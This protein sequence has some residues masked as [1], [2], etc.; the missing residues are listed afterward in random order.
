MN[1]KTIIWIGSGLVVA[2]LGYLAYNY[3]KT[4]KDAKDAE[5]EAEKAITPQPEAKPVKTVTPVVSSN[6]PLKKGVR[7]DKVKELQLALGI[8]STTLG[9]GYFGNQTLSKLKLYY[10]KESIANEAE[11]KLAKAKIAK[12]IQL[13]TSASKAGIAPSD[14]TRMTIG[15]NVGAGQQYGVLKGSVGGKEVSMQF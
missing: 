7:N 13:L 12:A 1:K 2:G 3:F 6:F 14:N 5:A 8:P 11:F 15:T 10:G 9:F 4:K